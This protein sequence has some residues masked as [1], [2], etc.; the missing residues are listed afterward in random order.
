MS[1]APGSY[2]TTCGMIEGD[3]VDNVTILALCEQEAIFLKP[4]QLYKFE[5]VEGCEKCKRIQKLYL[6]G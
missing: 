3:D 2:I 6:E 1:I 5:V 4:N